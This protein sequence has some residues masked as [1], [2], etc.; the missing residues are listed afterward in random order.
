MNLC[1]LWFQW[2]NSLQKLLLSNINVSRL[3]K[4][5]ANN[6]PENIRLSE[7]QIC[8]MV[9]EYRPLP[10]NLLELA[11]PM[12]GILKLLAEETK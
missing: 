1:D 4:T 3:Y 7:T 9:Q 2:H 6:S 11:K 5:L 8:K 10:F 12:D